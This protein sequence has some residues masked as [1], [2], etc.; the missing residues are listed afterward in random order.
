MAN[1]LT[2]CPTAE[3]HLPLQLEILKNHLEG[4]EKPIEAALAKMKDTHPD[5]VARN[6]ICD[7]CMKQ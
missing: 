3:G 7:I 4:V 2:T 1:L 6:N 5:E